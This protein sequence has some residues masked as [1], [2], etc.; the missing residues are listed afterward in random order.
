M[1]QVFLFIVGVTY[2][3]GMA[4]GQTPQPAFE[5]P[6][7][8]LSKLFTDFPNNFTAY[9]GDDLPTDLFTTEDKRFQ[10]KLTIPGTRE[11][12]FYSEVYKNEK[13]FYARLFEGTDSTLALAEYGRWRTKIEGCTTYPF[14]SLAAAESDDG[15]EKKILFYPFDLSAEM[16]KKYGRLTVEFKIFRWNKMGDNGRI[17]PQNS[18]ELRIMRQ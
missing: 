16:E 6:C 8:A 13:I 1:K 18:V 17:T 15:I 11:S 4:W 12:Y 7:S 14:G 5:T 3:T 10:A 9:V 2:I